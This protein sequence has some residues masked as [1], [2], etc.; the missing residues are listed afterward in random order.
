MYS[1]KGQEHHAQI[2]KIFNIPRYSKVGFFLL[3]PTECR[4]RKTTSLSDLSNQTLIYRHVENMSFLFHQISYLIR[5]L[6]EHF[7]NS[8]TDSS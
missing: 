7:A 4:I 3:Q 5:I 8:E 6:T 1:E 2:N